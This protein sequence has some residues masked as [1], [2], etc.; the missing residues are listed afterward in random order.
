[1]LDTSQPAGPEA[2]E[3][4]VSAGH[5]L[6]SNRRLGLAMLCSAVI[7]GAGHFVIKRRNKGLVLLVISSTLII[8]YWA[9]RIPANIITLPFTIL[10]TMLLCIYAGCDA[11]YFAHRPG[12]RGSQLWLLLAF[13]A[14]ILG[15]VVSAN[16]GS[17]ASG[18]RA[19]TDPSTAMEHTISE[20]SK[21]MVDTR[22]YRS[23]SLQRGDIIVF[24]HPHEPGLYMLKRVIAVGGE[25]V[26][27][28]AD[29]VAVNGNPLDEPYAFIDQKYPDPKPHFHLTVPPGKIFVLGDNR[30]ISLDS[31]FDQ[32]GLPGISSIRGKVL[33][34][35]PGFDLRKKGIQTGSD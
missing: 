24:E 27:I 28:N 26:D 35:M 34:V 20:G 1:M 6:F 19:Y 22:Y 3:R 10:G 29:R 23:H 9:A 5:R 16:L 8:L 14:G 17:L 4:V 13:P 31:R 18:I 25:T 32:F 2:Q 30:H 33:Y 15:A 12:Q 11:G 7:P 21:A